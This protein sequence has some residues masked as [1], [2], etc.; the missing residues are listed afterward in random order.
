[1]SSEFT[2]CIVILIQIPSTDLSRASGSSRHHK[3]LKVLRKAPLH[4]IANDVRFHQQHG[5]N[6]S[7]V[8]P[9]SLYESAA[10]TGLREI[11]FG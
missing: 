10:Q 3:R 6:S 11:D 8:G 9:M 2:Y 4:S 1:M 5:A 7:L